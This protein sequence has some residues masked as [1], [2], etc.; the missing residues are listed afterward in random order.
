MHKK[1][2]TDYFH[3]LFYSFLDKTLYLGTV[4]HN[5]NVA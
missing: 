5:T 2:M 1:A 4:K 3:I